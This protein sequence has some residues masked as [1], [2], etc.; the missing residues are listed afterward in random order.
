MALKLDERVVEYV[1]VVLVLAT[2]SW[3]I[4]MGLHRL[5][6]YLKHHQLFHLIELINKLSQELMVLG[7]VSLIVFIVTNELDFGKEDTERIEIEHLEVFILAIS[8]ILGIG[9]VL[10]VANLL[11]HRTHNTTSQNYLWHQQK[12]LTVYGLDSSFNYLYH[13]E[14]SYKIGIVRLG[15]FNIVMWL[16]YAF[17]MLVQAIEVSDKYAGWPGFIASVLVIVL[18]AV[19]FTVARRI[20]YAKLE[21]FTRDSYQAEEVPKV[22]KASESLPLINSGEPQHGS[23]SELETNSLK[24][25]KKHVIW[26]TRFGRL[27]LFWFSLDAFTTILFMFFTDFF[28]SDF[29][30]GLARI[31]TYAYIY[32]VFYQHLYFAWGYLINPHQRNCYK[33]AADHH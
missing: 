13:L 14:Q 15:N 2:A 22:L 33:Y 18:S 21:R 24:E 11:K 5:I 20:F 31:V 32:M 29:L 9:C 28:W 3:I 7:L 1:T 4:E 10:I 6:K 26:L 19:A 27:V 16:I 17:V 23:A 12:F 25:I 8:P 30:T